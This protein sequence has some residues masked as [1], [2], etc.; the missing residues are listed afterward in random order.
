METHV[1]LVVTT[2]EPNLGRG[3]HWLSGTYAQKF[4]ARHG[5]SGHLFGDRFF[6]RVVVTNSHLVAAIAYVLA[7]PVRAGLVERPEHWPWSSFAATV[8]EHAPAYLDVAG[9]LELFDPRP[10]VARVR[11]AEAVTNSA[12]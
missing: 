9:V 2:P 7:N 3:M 10:H 8:G 12:H 5:R 11:V 4:N 1:H 6:S